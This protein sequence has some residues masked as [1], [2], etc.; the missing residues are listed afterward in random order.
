MQGYGEMRSGREV[1][2]SGPEQSCGAILCGAAG[3][4]TGSV[5]IGRSICTGD[6]IPLIFRLPYVKS[7]A[8]CDLPC[9]SLIGRLSEMNQIEGYFRCA[10]QEPVV[11]WSSMIACTEKARP[12]PELTGNAGL[13]EFS[14]DSR[15]TSSHKEKRMK[16]LSAV[17]IVCLG[18]VG[19]T[20]A[21]PS[22]TV[23]RLA[24]TYPAPPPVV[25]EFQLTPNTDLALLLGSSDSFQSF[26][27]E[28][29]EYVTVDGTYVAVLNDEAILGGDNLGP[30]G[31]DGGDPL[32]PKTAWLYTQ[33]RAETL[34]DYDFT[35]G[36]DRIASA[37]AL[38]TAIWY[39]EDEM[40]Y[41]GLSTLAKNFVAQAQ[42]SG[43]TT[44]GDVRV[45]NLY[46]G[47]DAKE[48][49]QDMLTL[50]TIPAPGAVFLGGLGMGLVSWLRRRTV[51]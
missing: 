12:P 10:S 37:L 47:L 45:L 19:V 14:S 18:A 43:W 51:L 2:F 7:Q 50:V 29:Y 42:A 9:V 8:R 5:T 23:G 27:L 22:V 41:D 4:S 38:Q 15:L 25:G 48:F 44:T 26:C 3:A 46:P 16:W 49:N 34:P 31:P 24:G 1:Q 32:S 11:A 13:M 39:L 28:A 40:E 20:S 21:V 35:P 30:A 36:A 6:D 17:L 33:F